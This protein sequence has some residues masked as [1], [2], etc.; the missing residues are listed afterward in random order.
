MGITDHDFESGRKMDRH[1]A[2]TTQAFKHR[3]QL[4]VQNCLTYATDENQSVTNVDHPSV[5]SCL[6]RKLTMGENG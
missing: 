6:D 1:D 5:K 3:M 2:V 4:N